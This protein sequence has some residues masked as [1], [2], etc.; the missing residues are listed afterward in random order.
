[1][2]S[3]ELADLMIK[4]IQEEKAKGYTAI[5]CDKLTAYLNKIKNSLKTELSQAEMEHYKA[6]L[7]IWAG[8]KK[9]LEAAVIAYG[10]GAIKSLLLINAGAVVVLLTFI[11][12]LA[13]FN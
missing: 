11:T 2:N 1:M 12:H 9:E 4:A 5:D 10:Q 3:K 7:Q 6:Q 8:N 13:Q